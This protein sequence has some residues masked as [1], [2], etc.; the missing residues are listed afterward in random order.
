MSISSLRRALRMLVLAAVVLLGLI[1]A[2]SAFGIGQIIEK[3][4]GLADLDARV[5][6]KPP[7]ASQQQRVSQLGGHVTWNRFG[8]PQSLIKYDG[9]L[10]TGLG[11]DPVAAARKFIS[12]NKVLF[13]LTDQ[14][15]A[16]L[17]LLND[18]RMAGTDGHAV[19]F[20]QTFGSL[21]ATQ[22]GLITIGVS[23]GRVAYASSSSAGDGAAPGAAGLSKVQAW[24]KAAKDVGLSTSVVNVLTSKLD[25]RT[26]WTGL[27][28]S[29]FSQY[30]RVRLTAFPTY[31]EGVRPAY[32]ALVI[33]T[34]GAW[35][36]AYKEFVDAQTGKIWFRQNAVQRLANTTIA[37]DPAGLNCTYE[38]SLAVAATVEC[39]PYEGP[40]AA[41]AGTKSID[42][43]ATTDVPTNDIVLELH[44]PQGTVVA[45][46]DVLF[47]PEAIHYEPSGGVPAGNYFVRVCPFSHNTADY[48][49]PYTYHGTITI[50]PVAGSGGGINTP[51]WKVFQA[52]PPLNYSSTD[53]RLI[54]CWLDSLANLTPANAECQVAVKNTASRA[55]WDFDVQANQPTFT[56]TGNNANTAEAW[57]SPLT[58]GGAQR[59]VAP[60]RRYVLPWT[61]A[62]LTSGCNPANLTPGG[63]D[64]LASVTNLFAGHNRMHDFSYALGF[65]ESNFNAQQSN[66]G[67]TAP[68]PFP[69][70]READPEV[71]NVQAGAV[72]GGA[73]SYLGRDNANQITLNDGVSPITNQYLFQ[74]IAGAFYSP[75]V[76][77]DFDTS[78][79]A[80]EYTHLI[81]NR[82]VGGPDAGLTG[83]QAGSMGESWGDLDGAEYLNAYG[84][85]PTAGENPFAVGAYAT[86]N[87]TAGIRD[88]PINNNPLNFSNLG[89]DVTG[90]EVHA[91]GEIWNAVNYDI[92]QALIAK[93]NPTFAA[94]N[95]GLQRDCA[96][97]DRPASQC[98]GNRRWIQIVYDAWLLMP[99]AVSMLDARDAYLAANQ[100]RFGTANKT[101]LWRAF[102]QRGMGVN[103]STN[104]NGD[105]QAKPNF[106]SP[107]ET[108]ATVTFK[109]VDQTGSP[110]T[111]NVYVGA[112]EDR[113]LPVADT[114]GQS[115][116]DAVAKLVGGHYDFVVQASGYGLWRFD[117]TFSPGATATVTFTVK[118]NWASAAKGGFAS[119]GGTGLGNLIDDTENTNWTGTGSPT[120]QGTTV[121]VQL[122]VGPH[123]ISRINVSAMLGPG[124]NRFTA[125]RRFRIDGCKAA[126]ANNFCGAAA[127]FSP[128][129]TSPA[130]AF[131]AVR[132]RPV[133]PDLIFRSFNVTPTS[134]THLRLVVLSNQCTGGPDFQGDQ[135]N[136]PT[137]NSDCVSGSTSGESVRVA[138]LE[139]F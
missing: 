1:A 60:D 10:A 137:N 134:V 40:Y 71:G 112:Y 64:I 106:Q 95:A 38:G 76:D 102:A 12:Q 107:A 31:T 61:N 21:P 72:D 121:T 83:Y 15:V 42:V 53:T 125:L 68:G 7:S 8:T 19:L 30:Q 17:E 126:A 14:G 63:N 67:N 66:F 89:F 120:V 20:R 88:Y 33:N 138:E 5:G 77:G 99:P 69:L 87:K 32:E 74:P 43:A 34:N 103:A 18:S 129:F 86:G 11:G 9:W 41:P 123:T 27:K 75:C 55:P 91:D 104:G 50:N 97:G 73:P 133:A 105:D 36:V 6:S 84:Y 108:N 25:K 58:P 56:T 116:L 90:P 16:N 96:D 37:C 54:D 82:M 92:R 94:S 59:P 4:D 24:V 44:R 93:Y 124:Q 47:S 136:D 35:P 139:A 57:F 135:D 3:Q 49:A 132:P 130:N 80:H 113:S 81:S 119:G 98:P 51:K 114:N 122:G 100:M 118:P 62:W 23:N 128:I 13:R 127:G 101:E 109:I 2:P 52:N 117:R 70:G 111:G 22:D 78:V 46:G 26:D 110:V 131:P 29:G 28:V 65:T 39:G 85:V 45:S 48:T 79:F 115:Q